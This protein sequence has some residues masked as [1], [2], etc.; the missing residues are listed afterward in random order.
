M[1][2]FELI[3]LILTFAISL[4]NM[5]YFTIYASRLET[6]MKKIIYWLIDREKN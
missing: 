6:R 5:F 3:I 4:V 2:D 1:N